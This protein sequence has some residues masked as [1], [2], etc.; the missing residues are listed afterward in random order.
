MRLREQWAATIRQGVL[1][2]PSIPNS[3][4]RQE[5]YWMNIRSWEEVREDF[6]RPKMGVVAIGEAGEL[7]LGRLGIARATASRS[8]F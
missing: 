2:L 1:S 5:Q 3:R 8:R 6:L 7:D 4:C